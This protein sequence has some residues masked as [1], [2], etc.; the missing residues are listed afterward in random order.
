[1]LPPQPCYTLHP[2]KHPPGQRVLA[3]AHH[4]VCYSDMPERSTA[5]RRV[6][7]YSKSNPRAIILRLNWMK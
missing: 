3:Y 7:H 6:I 5:V 2:F 1:M 4:G